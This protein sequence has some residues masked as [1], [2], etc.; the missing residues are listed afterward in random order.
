V[1]YRAR[2][3]AAYLLSLVVVTSVLSS[4]LL[5]IVQTC[6]YGFATGHISAGMQMTWLLK[7][8][9]CSQVDGVE[10]PKV[11]SVYFPDTPLHKAAFAN[12]GAQVSLLQMLVCGKLC[13]HHQLRFLHAIMLQ[14]MSQNIS[15]Y[16]LLTARAAAC[17]AAMSSMTDK[18]SFYCMASASSSPWS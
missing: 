8:Y 1:Q 9:A 5:T 16:V 3:S 14:C 11:Q 13:V 2:N 12:D 7:L 4:Q 6:D 15:S 10:N 17:N 18:P